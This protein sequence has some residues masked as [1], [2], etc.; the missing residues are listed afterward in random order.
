[1]NMDKLQTNKHAPETRGRM[2][3]WAAFYDF[4][5]EL[6][7]LRREQAVREMTIELAQVKSVE[8]V[9]EVGCSIGS[10]TIVAKERAGEVHGIDAAPEMIDVARHKAARAGADVDFQIGLI[11][12]IS[13][14][15]NLF[16]VVLSSFMIFHMPGD[17]RR[18]GFAEM[19]R[20]LKSSGRLLIVD[21]E[22]PTRGLPKVL[23][24]L[25]IGHLL[26]GHEMMQHNVRELLLMMELPMMEVAG[27]TD[28]ET[29]ATS[30]WATSFVRSRA[31]EA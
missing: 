13:F 18:K 30:H 24:T 20:V 28:I 12:D 26:H 10:L 29:G 7:F 2:G 25:I 21:F 1:M 4:V 27:F 23:T 6:L 11:E 16:D 14:P 8:K 9:L 15:D 22:P 17:V 19:H 5:T 3:H 31:G